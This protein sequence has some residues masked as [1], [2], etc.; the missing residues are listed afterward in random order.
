MINGIND[1]Y[2]CIFSR[3][4]NKLLSKFVHRDLSRKVLLHVDQT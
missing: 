2:L 4:N 1:I 3:L